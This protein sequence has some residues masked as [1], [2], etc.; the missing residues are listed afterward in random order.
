[1]KGQL[2]LGTAGELDTLFST[3]DDSLLR[4][5]DR[6]GRQR[7]RDIRGPA[8]RGAPRHLPGRHQGAAAAGVGG[9]G[10]LAGAHRRHEQLFVL[11]SGGPG[12]WEHW[13]SLRHYY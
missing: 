3:A 10:A 8:D 13:G 4:R 7:S 9:G 11:A 6:Q 12:G 1:M 5:Q 2:S